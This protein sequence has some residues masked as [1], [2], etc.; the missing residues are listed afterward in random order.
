MCAATCSFG[1]TLVLIGLLEKLLPQDVVRCLVQNIFLAQFLSY[2]F[3]MAQIPLVWLFI[4]V[5][6][7]LLR[8]VGAFTCVAGGILLQLEKGK[9]FVTEERL[10]MIPG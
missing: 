5:P 6:L 8:L 2:I 7:Q 1:I 3:V 9:E 10:L 4:G